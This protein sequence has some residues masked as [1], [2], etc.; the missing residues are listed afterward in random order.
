MLAT[1]YEEL[2]AEMETLEDEKTVRLEKAER[3][4]DFLRDVEEG[5]ELEIEFSEARW[6]AI[7][8]KVT[9]GKDGRMTFQFVNGKEVEV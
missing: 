1:R 4:A 7:V 2:R 8:E 3:I 6:N 5:E 9:V